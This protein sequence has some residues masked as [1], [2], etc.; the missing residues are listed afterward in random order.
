MN[1]VVEQST[2]S[3]RERLLRHSRV[4]AF[5]I[6]PLTSVKL[7][8]T[9]ATTTT[10]GNYQATRELPDHAREWCSDKTEGHNEWFAQAFRG[11][12]LAV[13]KQLL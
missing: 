7:M 12:W 9:T 1:F 5:T 6:P 13:D 3:L 4:L 2:R 11:S 10:T 8:W